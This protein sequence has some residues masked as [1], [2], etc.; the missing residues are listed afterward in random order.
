MRSD[1]AHAKGIL[2]LK[3]I[4]TEI[5]EYWK[6]EGRSRNDVSLPDPY[7]I[8]RAINREEMWEPLLSNYFFVF[9]WVVIFLIWC[10]CI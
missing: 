8:T 5:S 6:E 3:K 1:F 2:H 10:I 7:Y 4:A 9:V